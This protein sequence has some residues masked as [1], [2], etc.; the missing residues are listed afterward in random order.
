MFN[1]PPR[2]LKRK[3][4][5][6]LSLGFAA[7]YW[8]FPVWVVLAA[9]I[10]LFVMAAA[11]EIARAK[12][13]K[14]NDLIKTVFGGI[15]R[16]E[17]DKHTAGVIWTIAGAIIAIT[18]FDPTIDLFQGLFA[19]IDCRRCVMMCFFYLALGDSAAAI[20]GMAF[21]KHKIYCG[22]SLEGTLACFTVCLIA[23]LFILPMWQAAL[24]G[25]AF[26]AFAETLPWPLSDNLWM[27][28]LDAG[29][30]VLFFKL[31]G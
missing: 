23:G 17:E 6:L 9:L 2:E 10:T 4:F 18:L 30:L 7:L 20:F 14:F 19:D 16:D 22:K 25:A 3:L 11:T 12:S 5:H 31:F 29:M 21:G 26:A 13:K 27:Q 15:M 1:I 24:F 8:F 28:P